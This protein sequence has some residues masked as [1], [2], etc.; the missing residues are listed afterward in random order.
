MTHVN[1]DIQSHTRCVSDFRK[2]WRSIFVCMA[3][4]FSR[5][6]RQSSSYAQYT[7]HMSCTRCCLCVLNIFADL[8]KAPHF[9][10]IDSASRIQSCKLTV[11]W[12][13]NGPPFWWYETQE[14]WDFHGRTVSFREGSDVN[15]FWVTASP[16]SWKLCWHIALPP[17]LSRRILTLLRLIPMEIS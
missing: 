8:W 7:G 5:C 17:L 12:L 10:R 14:R 2:Y 4:C 3:L 9:P 16:V 6:W 1:N 13:E 11:R 15:T